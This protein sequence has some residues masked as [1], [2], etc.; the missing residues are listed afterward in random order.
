MGIKRE[1]LLDLLDT[2]STPSISYWICILN[3]FEKNITYLDIDDMK[4]LCDESERVRKYFNNPRKQKVEIF[5][6]GKKVELTQSD[7]S[8]EIEKEAIFSKIYDHL[9][10]LI[11]A[12]T[13]EENDNIYEIKPTEISIGTA[14]VTVPMAAAPK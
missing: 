8:L 6:N 14:L 9:D 2:D 5:R 10:A 1:K 4:L 7:P 13:D 3:F 11:A 12:E